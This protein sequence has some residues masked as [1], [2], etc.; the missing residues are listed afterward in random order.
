MRL[1]KIK[2]SAD[3]KA[4]IKKIRSILTPLE[5]TKLDFVVDLLASTTEDIRE[6]SETDGEQETASEKAPKRFTPVAFNN[7]VAE[8]VAKHLGKDLKKAT[9]SL[10]VSADQATA[11]RCL[12]SKAHKPG[13]STYYWYAFHPYYKDS[14]NEYEKTF[15]AFGCGSPEKVL[16]FSLDTFVSWLDNMNMTQVADKMY[17]HV[18]FLQSQS[19]SIKIVFKKGAHP[20]D[21]TKNLI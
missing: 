15:I 4:T 21:V 5:L 6:V 10:Y 19:G 9:R 7:E 12:V 11:V 14:L 20:I 1:V 16:L 17:W 3:N 18:H 8:S 2:E 13:E